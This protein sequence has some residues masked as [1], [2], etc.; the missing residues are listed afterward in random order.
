MSAADE[1]VT[2]GDLSGVET[3]AMLKRTFRSASKPFHSL[4]LN[5]LDDDQRAELLQAFLAD[6]LDRLGDALVVAAR[7]GQDAVEKLT[8]RIMKTWLQDQARRTDFGAVRLRL[9]E[10]LMDARYARSG[11]GSLYWGLTG[12]TEPAGPSDGQLLDAARAVKVKAVRW[13]SEHR[14]A[15]M[16]ATPDLHR[17]MTAV[18]TSAS[19]SVEIT[20]LTWTFVRRFGVVLTSEVELEDGDIYPTRA[21]HGPAADTTI[22]TPDA[23]SRA[24]QIFVQ[25]TDAER[26]CL[27]VLNDIPAMCVVLNARRSTAYTVRNR[28]EETLRALAD[29][30]VDH[31]ELVSELCRLVE[32]RIAAG[33]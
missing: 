20:Q 7:D 28:L 10:L 29:E 15:P 5:G 31:E 32:E 11:P 22:T 12:A 26:R 4:A 2:L 23:R 33:H 21:G 1:L 30:D 19:G 13:S 17:V 27:L 9:E 6:R 8:F 3:F 18:L 24:R 14:R 25:L 16:A